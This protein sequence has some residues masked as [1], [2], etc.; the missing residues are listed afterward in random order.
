MTIQVSDDGGV[1]LGAMTEASD[2][3]LNIYQLLSPQ[4]VL[5]EGWAMGLGREERRGP[6]QHAC[7]GQ[8]EIRS[9]HFPGQAETNAA[10][11][12]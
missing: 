3:F 2:Q 5:T 10:P 1:A 6:H 11:G 12:T 4:V 7:P 9:C 8:V